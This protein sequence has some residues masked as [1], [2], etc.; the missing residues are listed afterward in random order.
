MRSVGRLS[1]LTGAEVYVDETVVTELVES[2]QQLFVL[3]SRD[4]ALT[5]HVSKELS[6]Q[7]VRM[8]KELDLAARMMQVLHSGSEISNELEFEVET[9]PVLIRCHVWD[10]VRGSASAVYGLTDLREERRALE[11]ARWART[12]TGVLVGLA[13]WYPK[14]TWSEREDCPVEMGLVTLRYS[15]PDRVQGLWEGTTIAM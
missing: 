2:A 6:R 14:R 5:V 4:P 7:C 12:K 13:G 8:Q 15:F 3:A 1:G 10:A 9:A 11:L